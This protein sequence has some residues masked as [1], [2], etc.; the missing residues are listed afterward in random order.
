MFRGTEAFPYAG[1]PP[2]IGAGTGWG[3]GG[4]LGGYPP[5]GAIGAVVRESGGGGGALGG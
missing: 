5:A 4:A 3:G 1:E 2:G